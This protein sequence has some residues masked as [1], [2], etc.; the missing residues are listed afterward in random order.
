MNVVQLNEH[1]QKK[2]IKSFKVINMWLKNH[3]W[4]PEG[5]SGSTQTRS[6]RL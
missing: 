3:V 4:E 5:L 1:S 2:K 6:H